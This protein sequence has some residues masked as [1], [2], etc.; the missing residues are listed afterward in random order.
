MTLGDYEPHIGLL[1]LPKIIYTMI[2]TVVYEPESSS[3]LLLTDGVH[4]NPL[5]RD[6]QL[7]DGQP[8]QCT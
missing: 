1:V 7:P 5:S 3:S 6:R 2:A 4:T 8:I